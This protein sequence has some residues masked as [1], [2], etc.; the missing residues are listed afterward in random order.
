MSSV[1][2]CGVNQYPEFRSPRDYEAVLADLS[3]LKSMADVPVQVSYDD[4]G[5]KE[6]W[7][8]CSLCGA[9]WR[10]VE[11]DPPFMG[12]FEKVLL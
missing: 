10:L 12:V 5:C 3:Q 11:P 1:C 9:T 7:F 6:K 2:V 8:H 4:V